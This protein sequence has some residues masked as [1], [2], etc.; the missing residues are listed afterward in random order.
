MNVVETSNHVVETRNR[1]VK[2]RNRLVKTRNR[3]VKT[4]NRLVKTRN[5]LV[6]TRNRLVKTRN[7]L[8]RLGALAILLGLTAT[9]APEEALADESAVADEAA[10]SLVLLRTSYLAGNRTE[11]KFVRCVSRKI[12]SGSK[13]PTIHA[14]RQFIDEL[15]PWLEPRTMPRES[16]ELGDFLARPGVAEAIRRKGVRYMVWL[17][18]QT[19]REGSGGSL[20]CGA[21]PGGAGC[22]GVAWWHNNSE[23]TASVWDINE[24]SDMG[25]MQASVRGTSVIP[26]L[27]VPIPIIARTQEKACDSLASQI[28]DY[29]DL[30]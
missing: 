2:T 10:E 30:D 28:R 21:G 12:R 11:E 15:Y 6:K 27:V 25:D 20:S 18:G 8:F 19:L 9:L 29:L 5:R 3:L 4:R 1:L 26:A 7:R 24:L 13:R 23:Y 17:S 14:E 16:A 22:F